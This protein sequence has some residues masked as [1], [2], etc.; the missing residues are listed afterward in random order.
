MRQHRVVEVVGKPELIDHAVD[1]VILRVQAAARGL[2]PHVLVLGVGTVT[3][4]ALASKGDPG[5]E[6]RV[7]RGA[8]AA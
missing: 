3:K 5:F 2:A 6:V 4:T 7:N 1:A 8:Q